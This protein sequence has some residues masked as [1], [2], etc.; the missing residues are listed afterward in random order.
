M[1]PHKKIDRRRGE[2]PAGGFLFLL[3]KSKFFRDRSSENDGEVKAE[4]ILNESMISTPTF[5]QRRVFEKARSSQSRVLGKAE[6][7]LALEFVRKSEEHSG[8]SLREKAKV[9]RRKNFCKS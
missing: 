4:E 5:E 9:S 2:R 6:K 8:I 3:L 7:P 1:R